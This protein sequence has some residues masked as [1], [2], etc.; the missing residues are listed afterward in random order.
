MQLATQTLVCVL[1]KKPLGQVKTQI[2]LIG[3]PIDPVGHV[4]TQA[5]VELSPKVR[6]LTGHVFTQLFVELSI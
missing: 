5:L 1:A 6:G 3:E 2:I 4:D